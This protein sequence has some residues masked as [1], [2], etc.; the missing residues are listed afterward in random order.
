MKEGASATTDDPKMYRVPERVL[1]RIRFMGQWT[2]MVKHPL[3]SAQTA[4][5]NDTC[6]SSGPGHFTHTA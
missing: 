2:G 1:K 5:N 6:D 4:P 3:S